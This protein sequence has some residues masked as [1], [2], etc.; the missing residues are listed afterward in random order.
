MLS[1]ELTFIT[2]TDTNNKLSNIN[3]NCMAYAYC[4]LSDDNG[5][6]RF[7]KLLK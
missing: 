2:D 3:L 1:A 7:I 6:K 5:S 4:I